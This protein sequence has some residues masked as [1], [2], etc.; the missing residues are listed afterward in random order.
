MQACDSQPGAPNTCPAGYHC[1]PD[2]HCDAECTA[3]GGQCGDGYTCTSDGNC[4][5]SGAC[6]GL[7]CQIVDCQ[8]MNLQPT[9]IK[10]T[11][12]AP[13][14][15]LPLYGVQV[16]VPDAAGVLAPLPAGAQC[17][18]CSDALPGN[19]IAQATSIE[20]G[21]FILPD[22]PSGTDIPLVIVSGKWRRQIT[23]PS[24]A[25]CADTP[26]DATLTTL[27]KS[28]TD[29]P[30]GTTAVDMPQ[31]AIS[32]GSADSLECLVRKLG[33]ADSEI[34][35]DGGAG[36]VHLFNDASSPGAGVGKFKA[37]YAGGTGN[38]ADSMTLWDNGTTP[39]SRIDKL[40]TYDVVI[41][42]CEGDQYPSTKPQEAMDAVKGYADLGGRVFMSHWHNIWIEGAGHD[43][44]A[45]SQAPAVW[46]NV[47]TWS[48]G[49]NLNNN[50]IDLI[51]EMSN[52]K[53][54]SFATWMLNV[55]GST[56]RDQIPIQD[57]TGRSTCTMVDP[58]KGERWTY[59]QNQG[60][61]TQNFQFTTPNEVDEGSRCGK[62]VFSD[63][64]V[65]GGPMQGD[66]PDSCGTGLTLSPQ[67]KALAFMLFDLSSCVGTLF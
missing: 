46:P 16:Y 57:G 40:S 63:M 42:S 66:Y 62:V 22:V 2:G 59:V 13:N 37:G 64:H 6:S 61:G 67:E 5:G 29:M 44:E 33:I 1:T 10:G 52:P 49:G 35:T 30:T 4:Q 32:T 11:I 48:N 9:Q 7:Q 53:G 65:S 27:P 18:K 8:S 24:V 28:A 39:Q 45:G 58:T 20:D 41:F 12:Y 26:L 25:Q 36:H 19:P 47:A 17:S 55:M 54:T 31:I 21:T 50:T 43:G 23:I 34:G 38:F 51:D 60:G 56:I 15:T 14:G 3:G